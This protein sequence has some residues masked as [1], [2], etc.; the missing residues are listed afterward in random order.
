MEKKVKKNS[1]KEKSLKISFW[2]KLNISIVNFEHYYVIAA[3][4]WKK[5]ILYLVQLLLI[6]TTVLTCLVSYKTSSIL[7]GISDYAKNE[8]PDFGI[9]D[10]QF[11]INSNEPIIIEKDSNKIVIDNMNPVTTYTN[12]NKNSNKDLIVVSKDSIYF[13]NYY[14]GEMSYSIQNIGVLFG[15]SEIKK[16][17][18]I[19]V[20]SDTRLYGTLTVYVF[21][22]VF[23]MYFVSMLI[24]IVALAAVGYMMSRI[25]G[26]PLK[27]SATF[28]MAT[29]A[30][31]LPII[32]TLIYF[33]ANLTVG[34]NMPYFQIMITIISYI[35][36]I[37][38]L[39][40]M[41]SNLLR[42]DDNGEGNIKKR[43][44]RDEDEEEEDGSRVDEE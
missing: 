4:G 29:S 36:M 40:I 12:D 5:A 30:M 6:F 22:A 35:Y 26:L 15:K 14:A 10:N 3:D 1:D 27:F 16:S 11:W 20:L 43:P 21:I 38:A 24:D 34:F 13:K 44:L 32:M 37:F 25:V 31:S 41:R 2:Q 7:K 39:I 28:A 17:D 23:I 8:L 33:I 9:S 18:L 19:D 42:G